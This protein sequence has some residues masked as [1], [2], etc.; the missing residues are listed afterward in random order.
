MNVEKAKQLSVDG[1]DVLCGD[2]ALLPQYI[3]SLSAKGAISVISN[4][5]PTLTAQVMN[6]KHS[7]VYQNCVNLLAKEVNPTMIKYLLYKVG[8]ISS[9]EVRLPLTLPD[10]KLQKEADEFI[11]LSGGVM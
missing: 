7:D 9:P 6:G 3:E 1:I 11:A 2:D 8:L 4:L 5:F 10:E